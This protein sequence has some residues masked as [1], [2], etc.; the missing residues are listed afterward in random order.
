MSTSQV[1]MEVCDRG[2]ES[3][4]YTFRSEARF[5]VEIV[6]EQVAPQVLREVEWISLYLKVVRYNRKL[7][8]FTNHDVVLSI[9]VSIG[10][11]GE[12]EI[13]RLVECTKLS[14]LHQGKLSVVVS[15]K[16]VLCLDSILH[17]IG[18]C[19]GSGIID[20]NFESVLPRLLTNCTQSVMVSGEWIESSNI[21]PSSTKLRGGVINETA[22]IGTC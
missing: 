17:D 14:L 19:E 20:G 11:V 13:H 21:V 6:F 18:V 12:G 9:L 7:E 5:T 4:V 1:K 22:D 15:N 16:A 2:I 10:I 8:G 3:F